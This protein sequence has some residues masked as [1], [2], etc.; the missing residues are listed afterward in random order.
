MTQR[1]NMQFVFCSFLGQIL[2]TEAKSFND[3]WKFRCA[4]LRFKSWCTKLS[5]DLE[6]RGLH[7][8]HKSPSIAP[9]SFPYSSTSAR[10]RE[11]EGTP[12]P[13]NGSDSRA[14]RDGRDRP[15]G[16][17]SCHCYEQPRIALHS[18]RSNPN[19]FIPQR[20]RPKCSASVGHTHHPPYFAAL[21]SSW[22]IRVLGQSRPSVISCGRMG[23]WA[24]D[25]IYPISS[26]CIINK[27]RS[28]QEIH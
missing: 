24:L 17:R 9:K 27:H 22:I 20:K 26:E 10:I 25:Q 8:R 5:S 19:W 18:N 14:H 1:T 3:K 28:E 21:I 15:G 6:F 16:H 7:L 13:R 11:S 12:W 23:K 2:H 4:F